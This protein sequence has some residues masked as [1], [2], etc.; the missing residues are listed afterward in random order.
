MLHMRA[1]MHEHTHVYT[2]MHTCTYECRTY[3]HAHMDAC[4][5]AC[6]NRFMYACTRTCTACT[7][8]THMWSPFIS[9]MLEAMEV[10]L[11][12]DCSEVA[13]VM[14]RGGP[15]MSSR[16][17]STSSSLGDYTCKT[18]T[19]SHGDSHLSTYVPFA[20]TAVTTASKSLNAK[21]FSYHT[22]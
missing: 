8:H 13:E 2:D 17:D 19:C 3:T 7:V 16:S 5:Y 21:H 20:C 15:R 6:I 22:V 11:S 18:Y 12:C 14:A 1:C 9:P 10:E 4:M